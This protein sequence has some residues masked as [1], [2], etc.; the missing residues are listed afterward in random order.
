MFRNESVNVSIGHQFG[1]ENYYFLSVILLN[2]HSY[3]SFCFVF[4]YFRHSADTKGTINISVS[5][6][7]RQVM[8]DKLS[9]INLL[10]NI[11]AIVN[12]L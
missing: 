3:F 5:L 8:Y 7:K 12:T 9:L 2:V 1:S 6:P 10:L 11:W 4:S